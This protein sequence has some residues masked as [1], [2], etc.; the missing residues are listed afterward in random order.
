M[1]VRGDRFPILFYFIFST[2]RDFYGWKRERI[3][4]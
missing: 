3:A 2:S 1:N 4:V